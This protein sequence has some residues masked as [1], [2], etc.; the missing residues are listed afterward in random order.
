MVIR[1]SIISSVVDMAKAGW[2]EFGCRW[3]MRRDSMGGAQELLE[4][5]CQS[6]GLVVAA[7]ASRAMLFELARR[8]CP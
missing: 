3:V 1:A 5:D 6:S 7:G 2:E 4:P 8:S